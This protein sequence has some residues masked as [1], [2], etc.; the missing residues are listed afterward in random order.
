MIKLVLQNYSCIYIDSICKRASEPKENDTI[1]KRSRNTRNN[2]KRATTVTLPNTP[3]SK[4]MTSNV[5]A[6]S[7]LDQCPTSVSYGEEEPFR[8][9]LSKKEAML[10]AKYGAFNDNEVSFPEDTRPKLTLPHSFPGIDRTVSSQLQ[11]IIKP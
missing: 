1:L 11:E 10:N 3:L 4:P 6:S 2:F 5:D 7:S 8:E 9:G